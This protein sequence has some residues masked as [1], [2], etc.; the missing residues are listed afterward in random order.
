MSVHH[1]LGLKKFISVTKKGICER[2]DL[3]YSDMIYKH[4]SS[5]TALVKPPEEWMELYQQWAKDREDI[6]KAA[7]SLLLN[8]P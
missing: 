4:N 5:D 7:E 3:F 1:E 6:R 2:L 8:N